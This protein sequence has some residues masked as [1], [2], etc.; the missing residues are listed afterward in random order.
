[1]KNK[2][3]N[4]SEKIC[5]EVIDILVGYIDG[6]FHKGWINM[7]DVKEFIRLLKIEL[8]KMLDLSTTY[9]KDY[10]L[11]MDFIDSLAGEKLK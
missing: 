11:V 9:I 6:Y 7:K 10:K 5:E 1:M 2:E 4:L 8:D 3:F